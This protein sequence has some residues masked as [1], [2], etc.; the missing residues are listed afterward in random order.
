MNQSPRSTARRHARRLARRGF[1][2]LEIIV[3]VTIIG[4]LAAVVA[5]RLLGNIGKAKTSIAK[6]EVGQLAQEVSIWM[7]D[8]GLSRL[9]DDFELGF[10]AEGDDRTINPDDLIDPWE[11]PYL[12]L[13]PGEKNPDFDVI[14]YG[15]D[16]Q[17]G[18]D[19]EDQ[20]VV[21]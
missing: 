15:A 3:V 7:A 16:G 2:L 5:P 8:Q 19:G 1:T 11:R 6:R 9:P 20:D 13:I 10:L 14:S 4:L 17:P 18:G 12:I 21:N